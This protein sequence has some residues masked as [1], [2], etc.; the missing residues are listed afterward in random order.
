MKTKTQKLTTTTKLI[1]SDRLKRAVRETWSYLGADAMEFVRN[2]GDAVELCIDAGRLR[3]HGR[4]KTAA[5]ELDAL[6]DAF[7]YG[8]VFKAI[9]RNVRLV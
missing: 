1:I 8:Q 5:D 4:D 2:N 9:S 3:E 7:E 6:F